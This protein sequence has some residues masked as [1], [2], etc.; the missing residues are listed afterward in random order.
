MSKRKDNAS[1]TGTSKRDQLRQ[2]QAQAAKAAK[3]KQFITLAVAGVALAALVVT[4]LVVA[5]R[6]RAEPD[7]SATQIAP[8]NASPDGYSI[9]ANP[10]KAKDGAIVFDIHSDYQCPACATY[11]KH[12]GDAFR[13]LAERGDI[14]LRIH[15]RT[16]VGDVILGN[17]SSIRASVAVACADTV[18]K[19]LDLHSTIFANQPLRE[20]DGYTEDQLRNIFPEEAGIVGDDLT[21]FQQCYDGRQTIEWVR[22]SEKEGWD[23]TIP[24]ATKL[25]GNEDGYQRYEMLGIRATPTFLANGKLVTNLPDAAQNPSADAVLAVLQAATEVG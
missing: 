23:H 14:E 9:V 6:N 3:T 10:G 5:L 25:Y 11:E 22:A 21:K 15:P 17:D 2:Q 4:I 20:G 13:E 12:F 18:G 8:P 7:P 24:D 16:M 1:H 19:A